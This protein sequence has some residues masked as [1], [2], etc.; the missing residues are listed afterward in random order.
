MRQLLEGDVDRE[1]K[2]ATPSGDEAVVRLL[3]E[4]GANTETKINM[5][6]QRY[7]TPSNGPSVSSPLSKDDS[8]TTTIRA[9][10]RYQHKGPF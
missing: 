10:R 1:L 8:S 9:W 4:K 5:E 7:I 2:S 6:R 3:L